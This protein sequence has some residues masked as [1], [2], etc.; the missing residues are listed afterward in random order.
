MVEK[1]KIH[2]LLI[3][4]EEYDV[5][6]VR[7]TVKPFNER[8]EILNIVSDGKSALAL[9][10][11]GKSNYDVVVMDFQI[12]GGEMGEVLIQKIK[13]LDHSL[14]IIVIT[15]MTINI[16]DYN[17]ANR[18]IKA[19]A[20]W[21][22]TKYPVDIE[23]YI[24]QPT[25]FVMS[26]FNA[27]E[28]CSLERERLKS[29]QKLIRNI[30]DI[31]IQKKIVG[32]SPSVQKLKEDIKKFAQSNVNTLI[33]G[34]SGT[35]KELVAYN[36]H[37]NSQRKFENFVII[38]CGSLPNDLVE[39]ELFGYEKGAFTG[40]DRKKLGLF[41]I[42]NNGTVFLDEITE[43][44][45]PAQVKILRVIQDGEIEK[46]GR[47][48]KLKVDVRIIAATNR[49]IE[50]EVKAKRFREDLYY[51]LNVL[52]IFVPDLKYRKED[53]PVLAEHF[54]TS[55]SIDMVK[56]KPSVQNEAM[57][58]LTDYDWP[59]N[60]RE[61]KNVVQRLLFSDE[62]IITPPLV[63]YALGINWKEKDNNI[64]REFFNSSKILSLREM[65]IY[66]RQKYFQFIRENSESDTEAAGKL[67]LAPSNY[68]RMAK[69]LGLK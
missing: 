2:V 48:E 34:A 4:D 3:E 18:L 54:M 59:G 57:K 51:R 6:R 67:G 30:E 39:S 37:F 22:C 66:L 58:L 8:I 50:E 9:L 47:T 42:A 33:K 36:I 40:A 53:I 49:D 38:N 23:E 21:Y 26:I 64:I 35:G 52:P 20:F 45:L 43:L 60:V 61:L 63:K 65:E 25:D 32:E 44:P 15:K 62:K 12:A 11:N 68:H 28:K 1:K 55:I 14:Q 41:E 46:I 27:Y 69:E 16:T 24:Y 5:R 19:G 7:N 13:E 17:F 10:R 29:N 56:D 31:L